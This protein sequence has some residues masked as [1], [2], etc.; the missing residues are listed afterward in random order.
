MDRATHLEAVRRASA[1]AFARKNGYFWLPCPVCGQMF[2]GHE[3]GPTGRGG[4]LYYGFDS[5]G[6][7]RSGYMTCPNCPGEYRYAEDGSVYR[8]MVE[9]EEE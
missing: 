8:V 7:G 1:E 4:T 9:E 5:E 2:G 3:V 6:Y